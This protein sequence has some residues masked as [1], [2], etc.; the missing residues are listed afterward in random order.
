MS[1]RAVPYPY[2]SH[3]KHCYQIQ[4]IF[5]FYFWYLAHSLF[6]FT[7]FMYKFESKFSM[8]EETRNW[9]FLVQIETSS[10]M[11]IIIY[12][13]KATLMGCVYSHVTY[14]R[15]TNS[16][17]CLIWAR[18]NHF[19]PRLIVLSQKVDSKVLRMAIKLKNG[20][21]VEVFWWGKSKTVISMLKF[22][23]LLFGMSPDVPTVTSPRS[24]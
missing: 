11:I 19:E 20:Y 21:I 3:L 1:D 7:I 12:M 13:L 5:I 8:R 17:F 18:M 23:R 6:C 10:I 2:F 24:Y 22:R 9:V 16:S 14:L 15:L 4:F